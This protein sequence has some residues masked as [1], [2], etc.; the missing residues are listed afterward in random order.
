M[1]T[2]ALKIVPTSNLVGEG[3]DYDNAA[4]FLGHVTAIGNAWTQQIG[5][6]GGL[7]VHGK[8]ATFFARWGN[9]H[10]RVGT[11][12]TAADACLDLVAK[13]ARDL[14]AWARDDSCDLASA[15]EASI[16]L[17]KL[18]DFEVVR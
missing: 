18:E 8:G 15:L 7:Y 2:A 16:A 4:E 1:S 3:V 9:S 6:F 11:G 13:L 10:D 12:L 14:K 5:G 17:L